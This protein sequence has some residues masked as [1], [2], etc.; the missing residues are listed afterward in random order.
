MQL[1]V[2]GKNQRR[3]VVDVD[4]LPAVEQRLANIRKTTAEDRLVAVLWR[5]R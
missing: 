4:Y 5:V 3:I 1:T 2:T